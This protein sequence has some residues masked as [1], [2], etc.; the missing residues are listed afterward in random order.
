MIFLKTLK[1]KVDGIDK[2]YQHDVVEHE[3]TKKKVVRKNSCLNF[4]L[5]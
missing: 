5:I 3:W 4:T 1:K 2:L